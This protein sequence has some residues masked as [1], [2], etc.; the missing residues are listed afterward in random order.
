MEKNIKNMK[1]VNFVPN[2]VQ[3]ILSSHKTL[4]KYKEQELFYEK[5]FLKISQ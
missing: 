3:K 2:D 1:N 4:K 5:L